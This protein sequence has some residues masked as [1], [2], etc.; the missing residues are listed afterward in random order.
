MVWSRGFVVAGD[1][2]AAGAAHIRA[3]LRPPGVPARVRTGDAG[4][5]SVCVRVCVCEWCD[6][7]CGLVCV[8]DATRSASTS[9]HHR[10]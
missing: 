8:H 7:G 3:A 2:R 5:R 9:S 1:A 10:A 6:R 4:V